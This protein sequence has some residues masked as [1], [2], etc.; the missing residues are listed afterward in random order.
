VPDLAARLAARTLELVDI[1][2]ESRHEAAISAHVRALVPRSFAVET[3]VDGATLWVSGRRAGAPLVVLAGHVD[4]VP[5][6]GNLP[7]RIQ[8]GSVHGLG[9]SD[10]KGGVA[11]ALELAHELDAER[12]PTD[13]DLALLVFEREE[14]PADESPLP[15]LFQRSRVVHETALAILLE[16]TDCAIQVGCVGNLTARLTF[17]GRSGHSARPWLADNAIERALAGLRGIAA[18][19][20]RAAVIQGLPFYEVVTITQLHA[21]V[22]D[23]VVPGEAVAHVNLRYPP[24]RTAEDAEAYLRSLVPDGAELELTG[25]SPPARVVADAPLVGRLRSAGGLEVQP[26]QAW[27]NVADFTS[28]GIDAVN[29][30]PGGTRWAHARDEQVEISALVLSFR[31][32]W[33]FLTAPAV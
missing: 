16:P 10:M 13:V 9:A 8:G 33:R 19:E 23:N 14:L 6:Q 5:A 12:P 18:L 2:S 27:T 22:A 30:G 3:E 29:F 15:A 24:D 25:N 31:T 20:R 4:T 7:G 11:V 26:K 28:R 17:R 32:L 21:G 1:P